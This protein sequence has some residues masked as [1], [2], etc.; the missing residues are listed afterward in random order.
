MRRLDCTSAPLRVASIGLF[1]SCLALSA[2]CSPRPDTATQNE[3]PTGASEAVADPEPAKAAAQPAALAKADAVE[4]DDVVAIEDEPEPVVDPLG[5][6]SDEIRERFSNLPRDPKPDELIR[7]SH[8]WISN[9]LNQDLWHEHIAELGGA[10]LGVGTDQNY[11]LA[12]WAKSDF[13][14]VVDFDAAIADLHQ[15]YLLFFDEAETYEDFFQ[16][17][18]PERE[19]EGLALIDEKLGERPDHKNIRKS[20]KIARQLVWARLRKVRKIY[21][22]RGIATFVSDQAQYDHIRKLTR[23]GRVYALRGDFTANETMVA[24]GKAMNE[25]GLSFNVIYLSNVEQY[26]DYTPQW[27]RNF[28]GLPVGE[29]SVVVRTLGWGAFGFAPDEEY[30][31]NV[32]PAPKF[33]EWLATSR[34]TNLPRMLHFRTKTDVQGLSLL[35]GEVKPSKNPPVV[36]E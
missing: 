12:A 23:S 6:V 35:D 31:Y 26:V 1:S 34:V 5:P 15:V 19:E 10:Y 18:S 30:H 36:A 28:I 27:R 25:S 4:D 20:Y 29:K 14:V 33:Q 3:P 16:R 8:Y 21:P 2:A 9:E 22:E 24:V 17:W 11:L 32:Q 7:N 13:M